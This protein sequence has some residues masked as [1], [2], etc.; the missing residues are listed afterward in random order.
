MERDPQKVSLGDC[1]AM[2]RGSARKRRLA[3]RIAAAS[4]SGSAFRKTYVETLSAGDLPTLPSPELWTGRPGGTS[5][6][7]IHFTADNSGLKWIADTPSMTWA[8][9]LAGFFASR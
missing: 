5:V 6:P 1:E 7:V 8:H 3:H 9:T 4:W 2:R